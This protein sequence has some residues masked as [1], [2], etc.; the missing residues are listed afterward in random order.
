[1]KTK[2]SKREKLNQAMFW[3]LYWLIISLSGGLYDYNFKIITLYTLSSLPI[4]IITTYIFVYIVFER[5]YTNNKKLFILHTS[6]LLL[7]F[8]LIKRLF[9]QYVQFPLLYA[10]SDYTFTFLDANRIVSYIVQIIAITGIFIALKFYGD[11]R[12][13]KRTVALLRDEKQK[14]ELS[15]LKAQ[16][17][18]HFLFNTLNS[19]YYEV[20]NKSDKAPDLLIQL[21][22]ILRYTLYECKTDFINLEKE[23]KLIRNYINLEKSRYGN[24]LNV[25]FET[26]GDLTIK[27]LPLICFS[28]VEN[29][30]KHGAASQSDKSTINLRMNIEADAFTFEIDNPYVEDLNSDEYGAKRG[31]GLV[32]IRKQLDIIYQDE[33][34][35]ENKQIDDRYY[36]KLRVK[37]EGNAQ[38]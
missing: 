34:L 18:P 31:I 4:T 21:S 10:D 22:D 28:L 35:L 19:L 2:I 38:E 26:N 6:L 15:F 12:K 20:V 11:F 7:M 32:N 8:V 29:A 5:Y 33:Y 27:F 16:V 24:R 17:H 37:L 23:V 9:V 36:A 30:F 1:M 14:A 25:N 13:E 3:I